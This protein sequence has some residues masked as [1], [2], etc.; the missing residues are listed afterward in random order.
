MKR[1]RNIDLSI[2]QNEAKY[3]VP[4]LVIGLK[5]SESGRDPQELLKQLIDGEP[6]VYMT[7]DANEDAMSVNPINLQQDECPVL[8]ARLFELFG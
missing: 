8:A 7:Y 3:H 4:T 5:S 2:K 1:I 6:R